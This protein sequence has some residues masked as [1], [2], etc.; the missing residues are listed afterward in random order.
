MY[1]MR[2]TFPLRNIPRLQYTDIYTQQLNNIQ[3][4]VDH[5]SCHDHLNIKLFTKSIKLII[6]T[7]YQFTVIIFK[8]LKHS[9]ST[10][11]EILVWIE[12]HS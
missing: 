9:N 4:L 7:L 10:V 2:E 8:G 5:T 1:V 12:N 6:I 3:R 11:S